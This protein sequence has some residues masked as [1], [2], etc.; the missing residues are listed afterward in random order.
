MASHGSSSAHQGEQQ[1]STHGEKE[2]HGCTRV[3]SDRSLCRV[4]SVAGEVD[5]ASTNPRPVP[6][7]DAMDDYDSDEDY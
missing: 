4:I 1:G 6:R 3:P 7:A 2:G 5:L